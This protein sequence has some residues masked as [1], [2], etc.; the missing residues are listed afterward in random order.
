MRHMSLEYGDQNVYFIPLCPEPVLSI[1]YDVIYT[2]GHDH[3]PLG[4]DW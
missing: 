4:V 3:I 2:R 1:Y